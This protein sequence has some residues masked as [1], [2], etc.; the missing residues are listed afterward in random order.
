MFLTPREYF[1]SVQSHPRKRFGQHFLNHQE[2][3]RRI[4]D[5]A[6]LAPSDP[7]VEIGPGLGALTRFILPRV[8]RLHLIELDRDLAGYLEENAVS[9]ECGV[10]VHGRDVM[11]FDFAD[12][13]Q[14]EGGRL[15][16][17]GNLPYNISS[18]LLFQL[19]EQSASLKK[20]VFMVQKE[21][22]DRFRAEPGGKDYGVISVLLKGFAKTRPVLTVGPEAF[23]PRPKV[24]SIVLR[25]DFLDEPLV[26]PENLKF[27]RHVLNL[28][29][30]QRRKTLG[31]SLRQI[32]GKDTHALDEAF[33][34]A[35]IDPKRR[36]ETLDFQEFLTLAQALKPRL[37]D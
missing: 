17:I 34:E 21:V 11:G 36:P 24:E 31:R 18:P 15:T 5:A 1:K 37:K 29:F 27:F 33:A 6:D 13:A 28:T 25:L 9:P 8:H 30:Q 20:A 14:S 26:T 22:G 16:V 3:A 23:F 2:T 12:L 32:T 10:T 35:N 19:V 4:V 7:T